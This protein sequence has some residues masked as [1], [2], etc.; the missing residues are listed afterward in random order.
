[1]CNLIAFSHLPSRVVCPVKKP[2]CNVVSAHTYH[3]IS[4]EDLPL[5]IHTSAAWLLPT[6]LPLCLQNLAKIY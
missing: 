2:E 1:M 5:Q 4:L 3:T 6:L